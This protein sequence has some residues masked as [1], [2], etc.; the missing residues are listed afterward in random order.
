MAGS[1]ATGSGK[2]INWRW[3][4]RYQP[5]PRRL[6]MCRPK[7]PPAYRRV[8]Y[9]PRRPK[10]SSSSVWK[11][12]RQ[13]TRSGP[14]GIRSFQGDSHIK[15]KQVAPVILLAQGEEIQQLIAGFQSRDPEGNAVAQ[16]EILVRTAVFKSAN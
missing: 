7:M 13:C 14:G 12:A 15:K 11:T 5:I 6:Y 4:S 1:S 16:V 3:R 10:G 2:A 8:E 9:P